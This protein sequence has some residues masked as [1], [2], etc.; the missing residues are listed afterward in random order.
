MHIFEIHLIKNVIW[1]FFHSIV[2]DCISSSAKNWPNVV[3]A[4]H[5]FHS[6]IQVPVC[7][8]LW[9]EVYSC[10]SHEKIIHHMFTIENRQEMLSQLYGWIPPWQ[11]SKNILKYDV[12]LHYE[13]PTNEFICF[14]WLDIKRSRVIC[15]SPLLTLM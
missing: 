10:M 6:E 14:S 12:I 13:R 9:V 15:M 11:Q 1:S 3:Q 2:L 8:H 4:F 5:H 7:K